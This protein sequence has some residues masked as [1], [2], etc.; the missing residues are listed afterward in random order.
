MDPFSA[1]TALLTLTAMEIVLGIDNVV[2][3][4]ILCGRLPEE[5]QP[6]GRRLGLAVALITRLLLLCLL[7]WMLD[8][9]NS[10]FTYELVNLTDDLG[11]PASWL[12][13]K[14]GVLQDEI[15]SFTVQDLVLFVGGLFLI[16]KSV[17]E[18][19]DTMEGESASEATGKAVSFTRVMMQ[20]AVL[21]V[22]Q[23]MVDMEVDYLVAQV[24][25]EL[26]P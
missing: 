3:I 18:V 19:H 20:V 15:N 6:L 9:E 8:P 26:M 5:Q 17:H 7:Y 10:V 11:L 23:V 12:Q 13:D 14:G 4:A 1:I 22:Y 2:F 21:D 24:L 25:V 16:G